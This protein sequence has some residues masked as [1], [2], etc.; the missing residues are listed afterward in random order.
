MFVDARQHLRLVDHSKLIVNRL[1]VLAQLVFLQKV[2]LSVCIQVHQLLLLLD[3]V[4]RFRWFHQGLP[5][6]SW[7]LRLWLLGLR[8]AVWLRTSLWASFVLFNLL[9]FLFAENI[10]ADETILRWILALQRNG[11]D[12]PFVEGRL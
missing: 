6:F 4:Q 10:L 12:A 1:L 11:P 3:L 5:L 8:L 7:G 9:G 2:P